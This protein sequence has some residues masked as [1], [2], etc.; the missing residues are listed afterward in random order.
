MLSISRSSRKKTPIGHRSPSRASYVLLQYLAFL[1]G[2]VRESPIVMTDNDE[3]TTFDS[4]WLS[5]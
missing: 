3:F 2:M 1:A 5:L 4:L